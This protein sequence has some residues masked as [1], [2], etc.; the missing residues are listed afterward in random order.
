M[1]EPQSLVPGMSSAVSTATTPGIAR[2]ASSDSAV[3]RPLAAGDRP[4]AQCSVPV[5]SGMSSM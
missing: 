1:I 3:T 5:S 4:S 2:M